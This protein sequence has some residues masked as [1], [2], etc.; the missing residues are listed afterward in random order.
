M[1]GM[2]KPDAGTAVRILILE[3]Q[4]ADVELCERELGRAGLNFVSRRVDTL[5][6]LESELE[7]FSPDLVLSDFTF[8]GDFDGLRALQA[9]IRQR[10][11][12][13]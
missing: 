7:R 2:T 5:A 6:G 4:V 1:Q 13:A 10:S 8:P 12:P 9:V 11:S 3:D